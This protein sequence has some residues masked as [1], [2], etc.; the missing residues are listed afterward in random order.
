MGD[1]DLDN[2]TDILGEIRDGWD[3]AATGEELERGIRHWVKSLEVSQIHTHTY[4]NR[5]SA[6]TAQDYCRETDADANVV[7]E[8]FIEPRVI[9][10]FRADA[11]VR[12]DSDSLSIFIKAMRDETNIRVCFENALINQKK[13]L[14]SADMSDAQRRELVLHYRSN[15]IYVANKLIQHQARCIVPLVTSDARE[16]SPTQNLWKDEETALHVAVTQSCPEVVEALIE[17]VRHAHKDDPDRGERAI[18]SQKSSGQTALAIAVDQLDLDS[19]RRLLAATKGFLSISWGRGGYPLHD[20]VLSVANQTKKH[21][22][23]ALNKASFKI[24][25]EIIEAD[26]KGSLTSRCGVI[27]T[28]PW[29]QRVENIPPYTLAAMA[30][31]GMKGLRRRPSI[32]DSRLAANIDKRIPLLQKLRI[33]MK[34]YIARELDGLSYELATAGDVGLQNKIT[35]LDLSDFDAI[36]AGSQETDLDRFVKNFKPRS[37]CFEFSD[38][39]SYVR[40]PDMSIGDPEKTSRA[41]VELFDNLAQLFKVSKIVKLEAKDHPTHPMDDMEI[42][43]IV[44]RFGIEELDWAKYNIDLDALTPKNTD[45]SSS[46]RKL[47]LYST[48]HWGVL[49]HWLSEE[50]IFSFEGLKE[51]LIVV[52]NPYESED[53]PSQDS[54]T[55]LADKVRARMK[56]MS[57]YKNRTAQLSIDV[58]P[59]RVHKARTRETYVPES[60][61]DQFFKAFEKAQDFSLAYPERL[62]IWDDSKLGPLRSKV[63]IIDNGVDIGQRKIAS[64][65]RKG[66]SFVSLHD[67]GWYLPWF[68]SVHVH[69]TQMASL[70]VRVDPS[71]DLFVY[72]INSLPSGSIDAR[73]AVEAIEAAIEDQVDVINL[74]WSFNKNHETLKQAI[75]KAADRQH[76][77]LVFCAKSDELYADDVFPADYLSTIS[78]AA[79]TSRGRIGTEGSKT[80]DLL[81]LGENMPAYGPDYLGTK[82]KEAKVSGSSVAT[83]LASGMASLMLMLAKRDVVLKE[84]WELLKIKEVMLKVFERFK[85]DKSSTVTYVNPAMVFGEPADRLV[86]E[87]RSVVKAFPKT[88]Y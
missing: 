30:E 82:E 41:I 22:E 14:R 43:K 35:Y 20:L 85:T 58:E 62:E 63:A 16:G 25:S 44:D 64:N 26:T 31:E 4:T 47:K 37:Q 76:R 72:R 40:L 67:S 34:T 79:A 78:V 39:L 50:G 17:A 55:S 11:G 46:I 57:T 53:F 24:L 15:W 7:F 70:V 36:A 77:A 6:D 2:V 9:D 13:Y 21:P 69:G 65:I 38:M 86:V 33:G 56:K 19:V 28:T 80:P 74:S 42:A 1:I 18:L 10:L 23:A 8:D 61:S 29:D 81:I 60:V 54:A 84:C 27:S 71:C 59:G 51:V 52:V 73:H 12:S 83:A 87:M 3:E 75:D 45:D 48:G 66:R 68:T 49:Y 32:R 88:G 5:T